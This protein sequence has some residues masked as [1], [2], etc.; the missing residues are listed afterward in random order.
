M[1]EASS[2]DVTGSERTLFGCVPLRP[3]GDRA[4]GFL[5]AARGVGARGSGGRT[6]GVA[7]NAGGNLRRGRVGRS[8]IGEADDIW[9]SNNE[10]VERIRV[11]V[12]P[13]VSVV[14]SGEAGKIAGGWF[15]SAS[16]LHIDLTTE[17]R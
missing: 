4:T 10:S 3:A 17:E 1:V 15:V 13:L 11:D 6:V 12:R 8:I 7:G 16:V 2:V 5:R 14:H 9:T